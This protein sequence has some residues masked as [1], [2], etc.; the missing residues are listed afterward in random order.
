MNV[1]NIGG[2]YKI[3]RSVRRCMCPSF[4]VCVCL[5]VYVHVTTH[6]LTLRRHISI[7]V[8]DRRMVAMDHP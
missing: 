3:G 2:D 1:V 7:T 5:C 8:P 4:R 6:S